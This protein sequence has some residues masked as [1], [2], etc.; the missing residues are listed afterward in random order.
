MRTIV[1]L[2]FD[3]RKERKEMDILLELH[4][5]I[6]IAESAKAALLDE[7]EA[8]FTKAIETLHK[9]TEAVHNVV[10]NW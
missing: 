1:L 6:A 2:S 9:N 7:R 10:K 5:I 4:V 8:D 3:K